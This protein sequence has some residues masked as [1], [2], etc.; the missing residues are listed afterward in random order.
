MAASM[1]QQLDA[2]FG[3]YPFDDPLDPAEPDLGDIGFDDYAFET[4]AFDDSAFDGPD[5][6]TGYS[7]YRPRTPYRPPTPRGRWRRY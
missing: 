1:L 4:F 3:A 5:P 2:R 7:P 6:P